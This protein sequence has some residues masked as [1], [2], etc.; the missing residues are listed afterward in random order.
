MN[1]LRLACTF[2]IMTLP[3]FSW[4]ND[5]A[6]HAEMCL[7]YGFERGTPQFAECVQKEVHQQGLK[8]SCTTHINAIK[9]KISWCEPNCRMK[10]HIWS[11]VVQCRDNC[12]YELEKQIP[13]SCK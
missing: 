6:K 1:F 5:F 4:A 7:N 10:T 2:L 3:N 8:S 9:E 11:W 13:V 12:K